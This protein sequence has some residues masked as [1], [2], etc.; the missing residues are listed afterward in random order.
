M[1]V[2]VVLTNDHLIQRLTH[3]VCKTFPVSHQASFQEFC[4]KTLMFPS[5]SSCHL[6]ISAFQEKHWILHNMLLPKTILGGQIFHVAILQAQHHWFELFNWC[7]SCQVL[8]FL[9]LSQ[10]LLKFR[11][12]VTVELT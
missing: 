4:M 12:F 3:T 7:L 11:S 9:L 5:F 10:F 8:C 1:M 6:I 2:L